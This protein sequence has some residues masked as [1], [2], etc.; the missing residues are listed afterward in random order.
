MDS[1]QK[2]ADSFLSKKYK[3]E[4][5]HVDQESGI[6]VNN[7]KVV[8]DPDILLKTYEILRSQT[9]APIA[10]RN[11]GYLLLIAIFNCQNKRTKVR[12]LSY[13]IDVSNP[14]IYIA[15]NQL[16]QAERC[17]LTDND[18]KVKNEFKN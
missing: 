2:F 14:T 8:V 11:L 5:I 4:C 12:D 10:V 15:L 18:I 9:T 3:G 13:L 7:N 1:I 6:R 16:R 17:I